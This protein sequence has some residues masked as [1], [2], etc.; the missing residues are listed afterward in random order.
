MSK[1]SGNRNK[2]SGKSRR[3]TV[4]RNVPKPA[5]ALRQ[6]LR[7]PE[8]LRTC[9]IIFLFLIAVSFVATWSREQIKVRDGQI[10]TNTRI[11]R[12]DYTIE[13][14]AATEA[15]REEASNSSPRIYTINATFIE[16]LAASLLGLPTAV[17]GMTSIEEVN[18]ELIAQFN[19]TPETLE[20]LQ[21][22]SR[23]GEATPSWRRYVSRIISELQRD[24]PLLTSEEF[25]VFTTTPAANRALFEGAGKFLSPYHAA[26]IALPT[27]AGAREQQR[28]LVPGTR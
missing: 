24:K 22:M 5:I 21:K 13:D 17:S 19:I 11:T 28:Q 7:K 14:S 6:L 25:Q 16:R 12:I 9:S 1:S 27:Q 3:E 15:L 4:L 2:G 8:F 26:A 23:D 20:S 10:A 18:P